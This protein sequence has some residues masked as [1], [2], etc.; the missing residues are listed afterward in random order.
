MSKKRG[1]ENSVKIKLNNVIIYKIFIF[2]VTVDTALSASVI[3]NEFKSIIHTFLLVIELMSA[4]LCMVTKIY[5]NK[6]LFLTSLIY[7]FGVLSYFISTN[8]D[9]LITVLVIGLMEHINIDEILGLIYKTRLV[10]FVLIVGLALTGFLEQGAVDGMPSEKGILLGFGHANIFAGNAAI[11]ILLMLSINRYKLKNSH[12]LIALGSELMVFFLTYTRISLGLILITISLIVGMKKK[13]I[14]ESFLEASSFFLPLILLL[15]FGIILM[16]LLE[17]HR[18]LMNK[19][20]LI[21]NGRMLLACMNLRYYPVTF[22]GQKVDFSKI[23]MENRY[24]ALDNGYTYLLINYGIVGLSVFC[25]MFQRAVISC[26][27]NKE[28]IL[29]IVTLIF[30]LWA[31]YEGMMVSAGADFALLFSLGNVTGC[32]TEK[33][34]DN[35]AGIKYDT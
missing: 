18:A 4:I 33:R 25:I 30:M 9:F 16:Y 13:A 21:F 17:I 19:L 15:N 26:K 20:D 8:T 34:T 5:T 2:F 22:L 7:M 29:S 32:K 24:Y 28:Y 27:K 31:I 23:A 12:L 10:I 14:R 3:S 11:L 35:M 6:S 1:K